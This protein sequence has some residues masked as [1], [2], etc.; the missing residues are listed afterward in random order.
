LVGSH[1]FVEVAINKANAA[2]RFHLRPGDRLIFRRRSG[3]RS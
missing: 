2:R 1:D 3:Y